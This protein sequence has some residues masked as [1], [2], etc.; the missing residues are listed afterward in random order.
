MKNKFYLISVAILCLSIILCACGKE[1]PEQI[2]THPE[3]TALQTEETEIPT[4]TVTYVD[5]SGYHVVSRIDP[6]TQE[7][8]H[9]PVPSRTQ[10]PTYKVVTTPHFSVTPDQPVTL[11]EIDKHTSPTQIHYPDQP[12][13]DSAV[14]IP[15]KANGIS[16]QFKS[17]PVIKGN[18]ATIAINGVAG[19]EYT[20]EVY[21]NDKN[22]LTSD[23]LNPQTANASGVVSWTFDTDN[24]DIGYRK[25]IIREVNSDNYIQ[26]SI[27]VIN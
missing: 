19:K 12:T 21:R 9:P 6:P 7:K 8:T 25:I 5:E 2:T 13:F 18:D 4:Q 22:T 20:V 26:T 24:C 27:T 23:K 1:T 11:P 3:T 10:P 17:N 16:I 14:T 15:E